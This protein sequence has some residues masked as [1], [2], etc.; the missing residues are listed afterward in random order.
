MTAEHRKKSSRIANNPAA[1]QKGSDTM[2]RKS[3]AGAKLVVRV[4]SDKITRKIETVSVFDNRTK[5]FWPEER[6][7]K[8]G[9]R[10]FLDIADLKETLNWNLNGDS[11]KYQFTWGQSGKNTS[12]GVAYVYD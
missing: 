6:I 7:K 3:I 11:R 12:E 10:W 2:R 9:I 4:I 5:E 1:G 8:R